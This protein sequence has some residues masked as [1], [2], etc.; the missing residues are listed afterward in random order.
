MGLISLFFQ[1][2]GFRFA[3]PLDDVGGGIHHA[4]QRTVLVIYTDADVVEDK[5]LAGVEVG[6][7][8]RVVS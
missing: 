6:G 2:L 7:G 3:N 4:H 5:L 8:L 1:F